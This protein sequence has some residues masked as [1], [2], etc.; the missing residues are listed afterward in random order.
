MY[1]GNEYLGDAIYEQTILNEIHISKK[2]LKDPKVLDKILEKTKK[3]VE[4]HN[5]IVMSLS[6]A[7]GIAGDIALG[8]ATGS[9]LVPII[10][11]I[12]FIGGVL[13]AATK[14]LKTEEAE[15]EKNI[16]KLV[17]KV[18]KLKKNAEKMEDSKEKKEIIDRCNQ[19]LNSVNK[20]HKN[21][22]DKKSKA[23]HD[24]KVKEIKHLINVVNGKETINCEYMPNAYNDYVI[25][26]K[27]GIANHSKLDKAMVDYCTKHKSDGYSDGV[28]ELFIGEDNI[29]KA[30]KYLSDKELDEYEKEIPGF[31]ENT[32]VYTLYAIDD[33]VCFFNPK[34]KHFYFGDY[35]PK[36]L[37]HDSSLYRLS[38]KLGKSGSELTKEDIESY[39]QIYEEI[40]NKK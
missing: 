5:N 2:D 31:K 35:G 38:E 34:N 15:K 37:D 30:K 6:F 39:K 10:T 29:E 36:W 4:T 24:S 18:E 27:L 14:F 8:V 40:K 16:Q 1:F 23:D 28:M 19:I 20:Y 9:I 32:R 7:I 3:D 33:T 22:A 11:F 12:P 13:V 21:E 25:A 26:D 17:D